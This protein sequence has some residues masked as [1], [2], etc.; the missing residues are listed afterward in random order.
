MKQFSKGTISKDFNKSIALKNY[1][2]KK[3]IVGIPN[4]EWENKIISDY[5]SKNEHEN[6]TDTLQRLSLYTRP[7]SC[8]CI[9]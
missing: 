6:D 8:C 3:I 7:I 5:M 1:T 2:D 9:Y 4:N